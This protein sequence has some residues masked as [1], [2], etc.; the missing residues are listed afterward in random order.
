MLLAKGKQYVIEWAIVQSFGISKLNEVYSADFRDS[1]R[2]GLQKRNG[3]AFDIVLTEN[4]CAPLMF[5]QIY[6]ARVCN[7]NVLK[8]ARFE[9]PNYL[10][11]RS[12]EL[13]DDSWR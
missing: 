1:H 9:L 6:V 11:N 4:P 2:F 8:L 10:R 3:G 12:T 7:G 13:N 5:P